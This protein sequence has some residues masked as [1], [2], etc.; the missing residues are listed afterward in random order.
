ME[1]PPCDGESRAVRLHSNGKRALHLEGPRLYPVLSS[2][3]LLIRCCT[4]RRNGNISFRSHM[5]IIFLP[6]CRDRLHHGRRVMLIQRALIAPAVDQQH[7]LR[8]VHRKEIFIPFIPRFRTNL[9]CYS[10]LFHL[11]FISLRPAARRHP[12]GSDR[13]HRRSCAVRTA[14]PDR[15]YPPL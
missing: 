13:S 10:A 3:E 11:L 5:E 7:C 4:F 12:Q 6:K 1:C 14:L 2:D 8:I 15:R 9:I